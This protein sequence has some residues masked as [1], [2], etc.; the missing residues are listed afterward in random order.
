MGTFN[1]K[2]S[3]INGVSPGAVTAK[4]YGFGVNK[5]CLLEA[6]EL[7]LDNHVLPILM[8]GGSFAVIGEASRS[9]TT[10]HNF[11][12]SKRR[13]NSTI[14][15]LR[16]QL[17]RRFVFSDETS[18]KPMGLGEMPAAFHR[19][20][21]GAENGFFRAV[22][23]AAWLKPTP[24]KVPVPQKVL[25]PQQLYKRVTKRTW[26]SFSDSSR[27]GTADKMHDGG[28]GAALAGLFKSIYDTKTKGGSDKREHNWFPAD[29]AVVSVKHR[30]TTE[31][32]RSHL[33]TTTQ[34]T[35]IVEYTYS[36]NWGRDTKVLLD[37]IDST[38]DRWIDEKGKPKI[39]KDRRYWSR[40]EVWKH[41]Y[42]PWASV[43][44]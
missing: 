13:A 35:T 25:P 27:A 11:A 44:G 31:Y 28:D 9:G 37:K 32:V 36:A 6:H 16:A 8:C 26:S 1:G 34:T 33:L 17:N 15:Y 19:E 21:D 38:I 5:D 2:V 3:E 12:L 22:T 39:R 43:L 23:I 30:S 24:P 41:T 7:W 4:L 29:F 40:K 14:T 42:S 20:A 18:S 10:S